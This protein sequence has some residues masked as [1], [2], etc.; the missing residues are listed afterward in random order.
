MQ[1]SS[2][3]F[4]GEQAMCVKYSLTAIAGAEYQAKRILLISKL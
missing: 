4:I 1:V 3:V 2:E